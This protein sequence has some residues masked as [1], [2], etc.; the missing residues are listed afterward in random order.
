MSSNT[1]W[2]VGGKSA[3]H[4]VPLITLAKQQ[5]KKSIFITTHR[6]L[7]KQLIAGTQARH[8]ALYLPDFFRNKWWLF[9]WYAAL[10]IYACIR[11][12]VLYST[13]RPE[14]VVSTGGLCALPVCL[15]AWLFR[16]PIDLHELNVIPG[17]AV[18]VLARISTRVFYCYPA[19]AHY[20]NV[21][22]AHYVAYPVRA[23]SRLTK[24][25]ARIL[26]GL[27]PEKRTVCFLG[28]SQGS[29]YINSLARE[30]I[31]QGDFQVI[32]QTGAKAYL[33]VR[34]WYQKHNVN[35]CVVDYYRTIEHLYAASDII[36][37]RSG[38]GTLW[39]IAQFGTPT[40]IIPLELTH[41]DHQVHNAQALCTSKPDQ[42][43]CMRQ[44]DIPAQF[45][46]LMAFVRGP[47]VQLLD[48]RGHDGVLENPLSH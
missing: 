2:Y 3:G 4:I 6:A 44:Q 48:H 5:Q 47:E 31:K 41:N 8:V 34:A 27:D 25:D 13:T 37:C 10:F 26:L 38:A 32:H 39:E 30:I 42:F 9:L 12:I 23:F 40:C 1:V 22:H 29:D 35:A 24:Q 19:T 33:A 16:V 21:P 43:I 20:L 14:R 7:D 11:T 36:I 28:G 45:N 15:V 46:T 17:K 18:L